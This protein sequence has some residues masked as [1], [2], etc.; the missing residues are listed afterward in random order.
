M[1]AD[2]PV[3]VLLGDV[4]ICPDVA[5]A[6]APTHAGTLDDELAL[7]VV[8]GVLHVLGHDHAEPRR[9]GDD[10]VEGARAARR[11]PLAR[12]AA[13]RVPPGPGLTMSASEIWMLLAIFAI[14]F[15]LAFL[16]VAETALNRISRVKAQAIADSRGTKSARALL[17]LVTHPERFINPLLV[18]VTVLQMGQAF[19]TIAAR[20][21]PVR[22]QGRRRRL[23]AQRHRVLRA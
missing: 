19:L 8:H 7:L 1:P 2:D 15:V 11:P 4:V 17:R 9:S 13:G 16:A 20:R 23:R 14:L 18:T 21:R 3:P 5:R 22:R 10:A 12:A 6:Q